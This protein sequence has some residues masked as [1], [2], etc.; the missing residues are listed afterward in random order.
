MDRRHHQSN[1][2][3]PGPADRSIAGR[4]EPGRNELGFNE[5]GRHEP[6]RHE[7]GRHEPGRHEPGRH[8]P[9][10]NEPARKQDRNP[11]GRFRPC[12]HDPIRVAGVQVM[13]CAGCGR[14]TYEDP[15]GTMAPSV[16][17]ARLF[18]DFDLAATLP[19]LHAPGT[20]VMLYRPPSRRRRA[21][22][23][24]FEARVWFEVDDGL[25]LAHDGEHLLLATAE[26][27]GGTLRG[28]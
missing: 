14:V 10:R 20:E 22:L 25:W 28:A 26:P 5:P 3:V 21:H 2:D 6:G 11:H 15:R 13:A 9:G 4:N 7:P 16:A 27:V 19:A 12:R 1:A 8:E 23:E 17:L 24:A 18:G